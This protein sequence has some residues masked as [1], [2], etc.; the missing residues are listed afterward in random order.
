MR[1]MTKF[2]GAVAAVAVMASASSAGAVTIFTNINQVNLDLFGTATFGATT[3]DLGAFTHTFNFMTTGLNDA[4]SSVVTIQLKSGKKDIDFTSV[5]L[6][7]FAFTQTGFD[8]SAETWD[9]TTALLTAGSH[10]IVL[11]GSV[12]SAG[13]ALKDAASY[14]G[15]LNISAIAV[16]EPATWALMMVGFGGAGAMLRSRRRTALSAV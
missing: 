11:K 3:T 6:D 9:L 16:P 12:V 8:P 13:P 15:T 1:T 7:G 2:L 14:S 10:A 5:K 4:S